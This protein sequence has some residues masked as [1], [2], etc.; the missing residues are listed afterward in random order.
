MLHVSL[1][2]SL[3]NQYPD[4]N[5]EHKKSQSPRIK[6]TNREITNPDGSDDEFE[7][8][9]DEFDDLEKISA[10]IISGPDLKQRETE[11]KP[12]DSTIERLPFELREIVFVFC[13]RNTF[14][15]A[16]QG[17]NLLKALRGQRQA[18]THALVIF[19]RL[20]SYEL[21]AKLR[22]HASE[23]CHRVQDMTELMTINEAPRNVSYQSNSNDSKLAESGLELTLQSVN[24]TPPR[25]Y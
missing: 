13:G 1:P 3:Q 9:V 17:P 8:F 4:K 18:Y 7:N 21:G 24:A 25:G 14:C 23:V 11:F 16:G 15:S 12:E 10:D 19:E 22:N 6:V 20:N 2:Y 5:L